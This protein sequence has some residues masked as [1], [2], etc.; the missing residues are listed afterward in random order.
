MKIK[1]EIDSG[2]T[3]FNKVEI[4]I[5]PINDTIETI[6]TNETTKEIEQKS[7]EKKQI[8]VSSGLENFEDIEAKL[9]GEK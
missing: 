9:N 5:H 7:K 4:I 2:D 3:N 8:K 1:L 6:T